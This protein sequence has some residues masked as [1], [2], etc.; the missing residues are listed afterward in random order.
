[1]LRV[2]ELI[3]HA[4][5]EILSRGGLN[6]PILDT[7][8]VTV[9]RVRMSPDLKLATIFVM[10]LGR[11]SSPEVVAALDRCRATLRSEVA[12]RVNLRFAPDLRFKLDDKFDNALKIDALLRSDRVRRDLDEPDH[13]DDEPDAEHKS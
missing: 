10:P 13:D 8:V 11:D 7:Q 12:R 3:R 9:P 4:V 2:A 5:A 6:D 1:M